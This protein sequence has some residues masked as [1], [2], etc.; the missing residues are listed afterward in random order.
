EYISHFALMT[1]VFTS[2][3][4]YLY[5]AVAQYAYTGLPVMRPLLLHYENVAA[6]Y[7]LIYQYVLCQDL[8]VADVHEQGRF[9]FTLYLP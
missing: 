4:G 3:N 5:Q 1:T 7:T 8:L 9:D 2:L 6:T